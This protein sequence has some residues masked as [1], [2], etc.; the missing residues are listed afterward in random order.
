MNN[1]LL[2]KSQGKFQGKDI[3][4]KK[5]SRK[6]KQGISELK[7][8]LILVAKLQHTNLVRILGCCIHREEKMLI[9]DYMPNKSLDLF[10]FGKEPFRL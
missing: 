8:E 10:L 4:V 6:S 7:N 1:K 9:Y 3:A 5:L 2:R